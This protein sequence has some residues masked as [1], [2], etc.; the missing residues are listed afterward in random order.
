MNSMI[1]KYA[2]LWKTVWKAVYTNMLRWNVYI[3]GIIADSHFILLAS[4]HF[5]IEL[6]LNMSYVYSSEVLCMC[7]FVF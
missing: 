2:Q 7:S 1:P 5:K 3:S 4:V 6:K